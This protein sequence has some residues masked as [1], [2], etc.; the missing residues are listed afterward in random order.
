MKTTI[1]DII[2]KTSIDSDIIDNEQDQLGNKIKLRNSS[3]INILQHE[4]NVPYRAS[5][6]SKVELPKTNNTSNLHILAEYPTNL[7]DGMGAK[8]INVKPFMFDNI[9]RK[10]NNNQSNQITQQNIEQSNG[11]I[12]KITEVQ[13]PV[14]EN[15]SSEL[16]S[17]DKFAEINNAR[18]LLD[19]V[20]KEANAAEEEARKSD[21]EVNKLSVEQ[22]EMEKK[23]E[24]AKRRKLEIL[25]QVN[26]AFESQ[27]TILS[28]A[29]KKYEDII[30]EAKIRKENNENK[31]IEFKN[32]ID[33]TV[34]LITKEEEE[35]AANQDLLNALGLIDNNM[36]NQPTE[37]YQE[38]IESATYHRVA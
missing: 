35:I 38:N 21:E 32:K 10:G 2:S 14:V 13:I 6:I 24:E 23:L 4:K 25:K 34:E 16:D 37:N 1:N 18:Q 28:A 7:L 15:S 22:T 31:I 12:S 19:S 3:Y 5:N 11:E 20:R 36:Q 8:P 30:R 29:R 33:N 27:A 9:S 26:N 17:T